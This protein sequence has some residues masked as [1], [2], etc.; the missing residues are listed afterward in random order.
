MANFLAKSE[1]FG[2]CHRLV[3][4]L[5]DV[6]IVFCFAKDANK[7]MCSINLSNICSVIAINHVDSI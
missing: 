7:S 3:V 2:K 6:N 4:V 5:S 1:V